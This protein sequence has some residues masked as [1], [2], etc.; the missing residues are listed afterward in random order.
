MHNTL[1]IKHQNSEQNNHSFCV[2]RQSD[3]KT[4][5]PV[6]LTGPDSVQVDGRPNSTLTQDLR[7]YLEDYLK[8]PTGAYPDLAERVLEALDDWGKDIFSALFS[9]R[10]RDWYQD[11]RRNSASLSELTIKI[12]SDDPRIL[13]WPWEA[14][15]DPEGTTLAHTCRIERQLSELHDPLPLPE[16]L[17]NH[18]LNILLIIARPYGDED[19]GYHAVSRPLIEL[20]QQQDYPVNIQVL[21]PPTF[22]QL[23]SELAAKPGFYHIVHFDGHGGYGDVPPAAS[24]SSFKGAQGK[25]VFE[26]ATSDQ[27]LVSALQLTQLIS[28]YRIP[29]MVLNA[30]QSAR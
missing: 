3:A 20:S 24:A 14:L 25:L 17:P 7:W 22:A 23:Q 10:A 1:I 29:I 30:C 11:I 15:C 16:H 18:C 2:V 28:E 21:R 19:V 13:A 12:A 4:S 6:T 26:S 27:Q 8:L 5:K 9:G